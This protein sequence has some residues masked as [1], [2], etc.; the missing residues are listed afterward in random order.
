MAARSPLA[1]LQQ[2]SLVMTVAV[3]GVMLEHGNATQCG[4][5]TCFAIDGSL[6]IG[7]EALFRN[8]LS[9]VNSI[10][11]GIENASSP[12]VSRYGA[13][14]FSTDATTITNLTIRANATSAIS[15]APY[16]AGWTNMEAGI[17]QC[18]NGAP[19]SNGGNPNGILTGTAAG[20]L[21]RVLFLVTDGVPNTVY[22]ATVD[23]Y[24][25]PGPKPNCQKGDSRSTLSVSP[26]DYSS[27]TQSSVCAQEVVEWRVRAL[28]TAPGVAN[29]T[30]QSPIK[31]IAVGIGNAVDDAWLT[32]LSSGSYY[33]AANY[34]NSSLQV[35][36]N[37][38]V[39][40]ACADVTVSSTPGNVTVP[41]N[42]QANVTVVVSNSGSFPVNS[43]ITVIITVPPGVNITNVTQPPGS[44]PSELLIS[45][46]SELN[47]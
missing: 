15:G 26:N 31:F 19:I 38:L 35:L 28:T 20:S 14:L 17:H 22:K 3:L 6:S 11:A 33:R 37:T 5:A 40:Q 21:P 13:S 30:Q 29:P 10:I 34:Q 18:Y 32:Q 7:S 46:G 44:P 43:S 27:T 24:G 42:S 4:I 9:F 25:W 23:T 36:V 16:P 1:K 47:R 12:G 45:P 2:L 39:A 8:G 41:V